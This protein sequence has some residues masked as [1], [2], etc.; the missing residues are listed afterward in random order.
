MQLNGERVVPH[1]PSAE[2]RA[3]SVAMARS[4]ISKMKMGV[5]IPVLPRLFTQIL[6]LIAISA[7]IEQ[8]VEIFSGDKRPVRHRAGVCPM[9]D[10]PF[11]RKRV[12][13][14][15]IRRAVKR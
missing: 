13:R 6:A 5:F 3:A 4:A 7:V 15:T 2:V 10:R 11:V 1:F 9:C 8:G 12:H 14:D